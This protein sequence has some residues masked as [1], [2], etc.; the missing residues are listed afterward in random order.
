MAGCSTRSGTE[1]SLARAEYAR[2][3]QATNSFAIYLTAERVD[4]VS[5]SSNLSGVTLMSAPVI[6]DGDIVAVDLTNGVMKLKPEV[7]K[8]LPASSVEGTF[9]VAVADGERLFLGAFWTML[10]SWGPVANATIGLD[11][12]PH[13]DYLFLGWYDPVRGRGGSGWWLGKEAAPGDLWSDPRVKGCLEKLHK[14]GHVK[15]L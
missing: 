14:L 10:S 1:A 7:F 6:S 3:D 2:R 11:R 12:V 8:R 9:F 5:T 4:P 13:Q 15:T